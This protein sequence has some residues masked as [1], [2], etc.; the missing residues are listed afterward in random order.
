MHILFAADRHPTP[1]LRSF[2]DTVAMEF[3]ER[4]GSAEQ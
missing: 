1:K 4:G 3:G 2:I